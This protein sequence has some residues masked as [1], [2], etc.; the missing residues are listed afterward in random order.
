MPPPNGGF[1]PQATMKHKVPPLLI[2]TKHHLISWQPLLEK[3]GVTRL[4][5]RLDIPETG[6]DISH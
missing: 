5:P 4:A 6:I 2:L 3:C 1:S